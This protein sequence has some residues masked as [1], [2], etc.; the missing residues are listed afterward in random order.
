MNGIFFAIGCALIANQSTSAGNG[1][2]VESFEEK[3]PG[4]TVTFR[5][6]K[7]P[8]GTI[9]IRGRK[10]EV[11]SL[12]VGE[13]EVAWDL[14]DVFAF[15][16]D[17]SQ[18]EQ[19]KPL[20]GRSR[21]S[22]PYGAPDAGF[23]HNGYPVISVNSAGA[24]AFCRWLSTKTGKKYRLPREDE[25][26][27]AARAGADNVG[28]L[29]EIAWYWDNADDKTHPMKAKKPNAF[30]LYDT[31]GNAAE[32]VIGLDMKRVVVGGSWKDKADQIRFEARVPYSPKWQ[33][34]DP[35]SP[36]SLWWLSDGSFIGF[37]V[38]C[39]D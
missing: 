31:L 34:R 2:P 30:G 3:I 8:A 22:R 35:Q 17:Q 39:D 19:Q 28:N 18:E 36:K 14:F 13:T 11:K 7:I 12:W 16:L 4:T 38:V 10:R 29:E 33:E 5:M 1:Q 6:V 25:W 37:R 23:G 20:D 32:W 27:Y 26:E 21:P 15:R 24:E 9:T